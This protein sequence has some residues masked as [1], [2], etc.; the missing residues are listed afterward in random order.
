MGFRYTCCGITCIDKKRC[1]SN[2]RSIIKDAVISENN[3]T[4]SAAHMFFVKGHSSQLFFFECQN[5][6]IWINVIDLHLLLAKHVND[7]NRWRLTQI[8]NISFISDTKNQ[9]ARCI[10]AFTSIVQNTV[11]TL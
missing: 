9:N 3:N 2:N 6:N 1:R 8:T 7:L 10:E 4:I 5:R 11:Y